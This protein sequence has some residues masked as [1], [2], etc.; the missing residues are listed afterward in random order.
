MENNVI[1]IAKIRRGGYQFSADSN[2][3]KIGICEI[4]DK[5]EQ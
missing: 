5:S 2:D 4:F 3:E 1:V